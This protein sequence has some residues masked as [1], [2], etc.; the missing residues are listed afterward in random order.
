MDS[1][2]EPWHAPPK[3]ATH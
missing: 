3:Q 2:G 1:S